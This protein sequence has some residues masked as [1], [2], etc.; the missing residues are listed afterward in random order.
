MTRNVIIRLDMSEEEAAGFEGR[1]AMIVP[2]LD[3]EIEQLR[4]GINAVDDFLL[5]VR[6]QL[7]TLRKILE[8]QD[9]ADSKIAKTLDMMLEPAGH[10]VELHDHSRRLLARAFFVGPQNKETLQ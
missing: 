1:T 5:L 3:K 2:L 7:R 8:G 9:D 6:R 4:A 10:A